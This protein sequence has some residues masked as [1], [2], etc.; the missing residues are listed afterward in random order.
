MK[1]YN[2]SNKTIA[3]LATDGFEQVEFTKP[4]AAVEEAGATV[5][6]IS[7]ESGE[8]QGFNH[9]EKADKFKV[10][11]TVGSVSADDYDGLILPGGVHNPDALR[12]NKDAVS[13]VRD[14]FKQHKPVAAI[15]HGPW[16]LVEADV[17]EGRTL[18]S[19]PS[20]RT[21]IENAGG[22]WVDEE[23]HCDEGLVTSRNPDD[24]PAFCAKAVEEF[25]E[26]KHALQTT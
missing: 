8:I 2:L 16:M 14:F 1:T 12:V 19:W 3:I 22:K 10:D 4:K 9:A 23:C 13:F 26:G 21:D 24:I 11:K 25:A 20:L 5:H 7:L 15:C 6:V 18:T 17:V